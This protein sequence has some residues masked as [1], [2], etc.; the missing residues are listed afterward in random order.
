VA[1][2][3]LSPAAEQAIRRHPWPGNIRQLEN[4]VKKALVLSERS[5]LEPEDLGLAAVAADGA[6]RLLP[7]AEAKERFARDYIRD[8]LAKNGGNRAQTARD[9]DVDQRTIF[10]FLEKE[11]GGEPSGDAGGGGS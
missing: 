6:P 5:V 2:R 3:T 9:L 1:L 8:A 10:R 11:G 4:H 7:L